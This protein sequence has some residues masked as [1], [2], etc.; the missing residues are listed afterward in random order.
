M[1]CFNCFT[2]SAV[3]LEHLT[4]P[5]MDQGLDK[6]LTNDEQMN[7]TKGVQNSR[8]GLHQLL[9]HRTILLHIYF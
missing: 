2:F 9:M 7:F 4:V 6:Q 1:A 8:K 3:S 5:G